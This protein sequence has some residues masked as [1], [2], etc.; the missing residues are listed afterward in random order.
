MASIL[1]SLYIPATAYTRDHCIKLFK[2]HYSKLLVR[3]NFF[4][5]NVNNS[6]NNLIYQMRLFP[7]TL[8][9]SLAG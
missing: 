1:L 5:Q 9:D 2:F 7:L 6:W 8:S 4:T 3:S